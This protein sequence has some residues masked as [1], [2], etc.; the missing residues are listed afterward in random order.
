MIRCSCLLCVSFV[1]IPYVRPQFVLSVAAIN[2]TSHRTLIC[3]FSG[4]VSVR[5]MTLKGDPSKGDERTVLFMTDE[6]PR[7]YEMRIFRE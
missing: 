5:I 3:R 7:L 1:H 4:T 6:F 2:T